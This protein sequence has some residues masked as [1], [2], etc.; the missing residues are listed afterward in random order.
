MFSQNGSW[1]VLFVVIMAT[2][3]KIVKSISLNPVNYSRIIITNDPPPPQNENRH[4]FQILPA[5]DL[6]IFKLINRQY[7]CGN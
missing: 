2:V 3:G 1:V 7:L 5:S 4:R 6:I